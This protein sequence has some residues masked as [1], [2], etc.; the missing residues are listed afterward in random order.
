MTSEF[1]DKIDGVRVQ[2]ES[3]AKTARNR[4]ESEFAAARAREL[5]DQ[6]QRYYADLRWPKLTD[7]E[8]EYGQQ[9]IVRPR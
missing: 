4:D 3:I 1:I 2:L 7:F 8:Y 5:Y 9:M 6:V